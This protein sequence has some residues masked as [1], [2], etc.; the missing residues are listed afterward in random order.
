MIPLLLSIS[1][2]LSTQKT[3]SLVYLTFIFTL[4]SSNFFISS[5]DK[6]PWSFP[7]NNTIKEIVADLQN[8]NPNSLYIL[9]NET[10]LNALSI[11]NYTCY[12]NQKFLSLCP[13]IAEVSYF[14]S[15][16]S[17]HPSFTTSDYFLV[18][19]QTLNITSDP[20]LKNLSQFIISHPQYYQ[21]I[22]TYFPN[23]KNKITL[24]HLLKYPQSK[25]FKQLE[26][27][28]TQYFNYD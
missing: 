1:L 10:W 4:V 26:E 22:K 8:I 27:S 18:N 23:D 6:K 11:K 3:K 5:L 9:S 20:A 2:W 13:H 25:D 24:Y 7:E 28:V 14:A 17:F 15:V 19:D 21:S 12:F 16:D